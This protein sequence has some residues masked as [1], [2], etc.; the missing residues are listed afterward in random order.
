MWDMEYIGMEHNSSEHTDY[1]AWVLNFG[2][3][4]ESC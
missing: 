4:K 3:M 2:N 1:G